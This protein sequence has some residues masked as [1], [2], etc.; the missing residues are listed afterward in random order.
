MK[1]SEWAKKWAIPQEAMDEF[2]AIA[3]MLPEPRITDGVLEAD[4]QARIKLEAS[5]LGLRLFRNNSGAFT[6]GYGNF[7]RFG[8]ANESDKIN[9]VFKS[10]DLLGIRTIHI[11]P[12][13]VGLKLGQFMAR[14]TKRESWFYRGTEIEEAQ[15]NFINFINTMGGDAA[16]CNSEGSF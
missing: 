4:V 7:V 1:L 15:L 5:Q 12:K 8:V 2:T 9:K 14:E 3:G 6:D 13:H 10:S 16:F 11:K